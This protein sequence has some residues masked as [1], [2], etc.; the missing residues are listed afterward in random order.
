MDG[1]REGTRER[2]E[3]LFIQNKQLSVYTQLVNK[4][5]WY[6]GLRRFLYCPLSFAPKFFSAHEDH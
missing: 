2:S 6:L 1:G 4:F 3:F 5:M